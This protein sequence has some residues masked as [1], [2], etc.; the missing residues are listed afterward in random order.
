MIGI[1]NQVSPDAW[2]SFF[3][4]V[5]GCAFLAGVLYANFKTMDQRIK[6]CEQEALRAHN[7]IDSI[8]TS[9]KLEAKVNQV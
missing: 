9:K 4:W 5:I 2:V 1:L 6:W 3:G 7:R 8:M